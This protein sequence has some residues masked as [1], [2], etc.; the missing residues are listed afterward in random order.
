[1]P[2]RLEEKPV[3]RDVQDAGRLD[4]FESRFGCSWSVSIRASGNSALMVRASWPVPA[5]GA[6][7]TLERSSAVVML[8]RA[9][10]AAA[11]L[12]VA[13]GGGGAGGGGADFTVTQDAAP[14]FSRL[15]EL[16]RL[17]ADGDCRGPR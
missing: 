14:P 17:A 3:S 7:Y 12:G 13:V 11:T 6:K 2:A 16:N 15:A 1:L 9:A 4:L 5:S 8:R 10:P